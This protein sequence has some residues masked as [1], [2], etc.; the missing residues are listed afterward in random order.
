[1]SREI[2]LHSDL[3]HAGI[4]CMYA[5]WKDRLHVYIAMEWAPGVR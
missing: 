3:N 5:A 1:M 4:I 2:K